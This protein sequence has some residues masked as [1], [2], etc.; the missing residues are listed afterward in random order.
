MRPVVSR[1]ISRGV[2]CSPA[3]SFELANLLY[4]VVQKFA[5][6]DLSPENISNHDMGLVF[7]ELIRRF[8]SALLRFRSN[9]QQNA[10]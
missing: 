6:T 2:K 3:V 5:S 4:K 1:T 9:F 10:E 8:E 7:E